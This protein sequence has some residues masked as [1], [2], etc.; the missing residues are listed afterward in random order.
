MSREYTRDETRNALLDHIWT[1]I[2]FWRHETRATTDQERL[3]GLAFSILSTLDG[4]NGDIPKFIVAPD[5][6]PE[7]RPFRISSGE[8]Y[9]P[10]NQA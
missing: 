2:H 5:P 9:F 10:E 6:H 8:D 1:L 7:D 3:E 4:E